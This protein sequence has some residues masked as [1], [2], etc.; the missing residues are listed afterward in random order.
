MVDAGCG[1]VDSVKYVRSGGEGVTRRFR[2]LAQSTGSVSGSQKVNQYIQEMIEN[3]VPEGIE[4]EYTRLGKEPNEFTFE[5][6]AQIE[7]C[8]KEFFP[9]HLDETST[10]SE[11]TLLGAVSIINPRTKEEFRCRITAYVSELGSCASHL[12]LQN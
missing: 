8:K 9:Y 11:E 2:A 3:Q 7:R 1:T 6:L 10:A 5:L 4:S 12:L